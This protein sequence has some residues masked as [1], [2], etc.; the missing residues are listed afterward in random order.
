MVFRAPTEPTQAS[1]KRLIG[2][3]GETVEI[4]EGEIHINGAVVSKP[5]SLAWLRYDG[6][7]TVRDRVGHGGTGSP[8]HLGAGEY[9]VLG[10]NTKQSLDSRFWERGALGAQPGAVPQMMM[11]G[12]VRA[13]YAPPGRARLFR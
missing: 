10:D 11:I 9:Y 3:P 1:V 13:I 6:A 12:T 2:L 8:I 5:E 7:M 4:V